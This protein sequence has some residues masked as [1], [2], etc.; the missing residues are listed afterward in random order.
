MDG[1]T[2]T[3]DMYF[4]VPQAGKSKIKV[5]AG[6]TMV[7]MLFW[8]AM[9]AFLLYAHVVFPSV[10]VCGDYELQSLFL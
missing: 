6:F 10:C 2:S 4:T 9:V 1:V 3:T 5:L 8:L 7:R